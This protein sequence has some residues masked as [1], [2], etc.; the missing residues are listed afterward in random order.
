MSLKKKRK[1]DIT[2]FKIET[3]KVLCLPLL[4]TDMSCVSNDVCVK[5]GLNFRP[6]RVWR[7]HFDDY[8]KTIL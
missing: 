7:R 6:Y 4:L 8:K 5:V 2:S 3:E 1:T